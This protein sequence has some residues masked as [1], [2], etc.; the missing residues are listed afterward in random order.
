MALLNVHIY[1]TALKIIVFDMVDVIVI[2]VSGLL[3]CY[4]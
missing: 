3:Y 4:N 2:D 1:E